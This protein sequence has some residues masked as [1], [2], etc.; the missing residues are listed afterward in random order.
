MVA[1]NLPTIAVGR[2]SEDFGNA[3]V[4]RVNDTQRAVLGLQ[5]NILGNWKLDAYAE[6]GH[7]RDAFT[8]QNN[9]IKGN[10]ALA[11]DAVVSGGQVV[12][13]STL[14][15]PSNGCV[16]LNIFGPGSASPAAIGYVYG[17]SRAILDLTEEVAAASLSGEPFSTWAGPVSFATGAGYRR[18]SAVQMADAASQSGAFAIGNPKAL[19][20]SF[21]VKEVFGETV[22]P[23]A[24]DA[25]LLRTLDL[26]G[27]VRYTDYSTS[28]S[29]VTWKIG[30]NWEPVHGIRFRGTRSRDIRAPNILELFSAPIQQTAFLIDPTNNTQPSVQTFSLGNPKLIPE[31]TDTVSGGVVVRPDFAPRFEFSVDYYN[32]KIRDAIATLALQD[33]VNRCAAG[34]TTLCALITRTNG[35]ITAINNPYLNLQALKTAGL[36]IEVSYRLPIGPGTATARILAN[37]VFSYS[38]SDGVTTIDRVGDISNAQPK[39]TGNATIGYQLGG[40][41]GTADISYIGPGKYDVTYVLPTDVNDNHI[42]S[43]TVVDFQV[44]YD[45]GAAGHRRQFF[46]NVANAFDVRPPAIFVFSGGPNYDRVGRAFRAGFRFTI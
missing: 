25:P 37:R 43:N 45:L 1:L 2:Y 8:I 30:A 42:P 9:A 26:N 40:F 22:I 35:T 39:W 6:Y 23:L 12:C 11:A 36:D 31:K 13:R 14:A 27:A 16:P 5:G 28:G 32:I 15:N 17:T 10:L 44:S 41:L 4:S 29:V 38:T 20:G 18:E 46:L 3:V 24:K 19:S 34:N 7:N 21:D 33:V